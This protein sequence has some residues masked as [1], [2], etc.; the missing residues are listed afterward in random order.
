MAV[1]WL[2]TWPSGWPDLDDIMPRVVL[3]VVPRGLL[4]LSRDNQAGLDWYAAGLSLG[5]ARKWLEWVY[6]RFAP[7]VDTEDTQTDRW[8]DDFQVYKRSGGIARRMWIAAKM[9]QRGTS[10]DDL[11]KQIMAGA[12][13][14]LDPDILA[15]FRQE[16]IAP[17]TEPDTGLQFREGAH[18]HIYHAA[19][20][21]APDFAE[22]EALIEQIKPTWATWT[23]GQYQI[24]Q[25]DDPGSGWDRGCWEPL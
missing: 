22:A 8:G 17:V 6:R 7:H 13:E 11:V 1:A 19:E 15:T 12:W 25:Y 4:K 3:R 21:D 24:M 9:R 10:T 23:V 14:S 16:P 18:V 5:M 20:T 2:P